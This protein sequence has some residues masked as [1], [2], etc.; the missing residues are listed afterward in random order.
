MARKLRIQYENALYHVINRGNYRRDVFETAGA[1]RVFEE[2][3]WKCCR[4][5]EWRLHAHVVMRNHFHLAVETPRANLMEGMHWLLGTFS[6]RFNRFREERG[7]LFQGR[8]QAILVE[9]GAALVRVADYIHLNPVRA[10][11]VPV[12][13]VAQFRWSSLRHFV[14]APRPSFLVAD[15][16]LGNSGLDDSPGGWREYVEQLQ[17][18]ALN[19]AEQERR[20]FGEM[21]RGWAIGTA[22]W[23][24][25]LAKTY[26][27]MA[28]H[29]GLE[30]KELRDL[31][32][33]RWNDALDQALRESGKTLEQVEKESRRN[34]WKIELAR[35]LRE[36]GVPYAW[37]SKRLHLGSPDALRVRVHRLNGRFEM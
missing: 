16:L 19:A 21:S 33:A 31:K 26:S 29:P 12:D 4:M 24:K 6:T 2:C 17:L 15:D 23:R 35:E 18:L 27:Q 30:Q 36:A 20:G 34:R 1:A 10:E 28:L 14:R 9:D 13:Q 7:H 32:E 22:G 5:H 8:Y 11:I 37:I 25:A 3:L